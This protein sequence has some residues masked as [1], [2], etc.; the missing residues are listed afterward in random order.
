[1]I[2]FIELGN[3]RAF[4]NQRFDFG[5]IN[6]FVGPNNAGKSSALSAIN[7]IAQTV[8]ERPRDVP[9]ALTGRYDDLGTFHDIVHGNNPRTK[10]NLKFGSNRFAYS[11]QFKYRTQRREIEI[12]RYEI[13]KR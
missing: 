6:I 4:R 9:L 5:R 7:L 2:D 10:L 8:Q 13:T 11:I 12:A 1:M 3:F